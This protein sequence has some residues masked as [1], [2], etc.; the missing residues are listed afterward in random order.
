MAMF[1]LIDVDAV[2]ALRDSQ[3]GI[4]FATSIEVVSQ[5]EGLHEET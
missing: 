5:G 4:A 3:V 1:V 2:W